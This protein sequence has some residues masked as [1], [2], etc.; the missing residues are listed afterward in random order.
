[1]T[2]QEACQKLN[3]TPSLS[4]APLIK[5]KA[6]VPNIPFPVTSLWQQA[7]KRFIAS[8]HKIL[9]AQSKI[10]EY[11]SQRGF[12]LDTIQHFSL[13]WNSQDLFEER[14]NWGIPP[15]INEN[16][17]PRRQWLPQGIVIPTYVNHE[18]MKIKIRRSAWTKEDSLPKYVEISG[19]SQSL[20]IYGD[21][22]KPI[23]IVESELDA[24]LI[25]QEAGH[26]ICSLALGGVSKKP[27]AQTHRW[28]SLAPLILLS[29]DFD[30][31]GKKKYAFWMTLYP[32]LRPWPTPCAKSLGDAI[33]IFSIDVL[34]WINS[35]LI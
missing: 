13:G 18:P 9:M 4:N 26:L 34:K 5:R 30:E 6:F 12:T 19:S 8:S 23:I 22:S 20:S 16:G 15:E 27:D 14:G 32:N 2:F 29:L 3:F 10:I 17:Y 11:L 28:L 33:T 1:M 7:A 25:Q 35:G 24:M 31:A 21:K